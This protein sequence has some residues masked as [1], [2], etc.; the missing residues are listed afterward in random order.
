[1]KRI[2]RFL[3]LGLAALP[4]VF[5]IPADEESSEAPAPAT[6]S[7]NHLAKFREWQKSPGSTENG[8]ALAKQRKQKML[9]LMADDP[10]A[11]IEEA[12]GWDEY[13]ALPAAVRQHVEQPF[14]GGQDSYQVEIE[15]GPVPRIRAEFDG[16]MA[17][18][19]GRRMQNP[20]SRREH[21]AQGIRLD[22]RVVLRENHVQRLTVSEARALHRHFP[23]ANPNPQFDIM[24]GERID[25]ATEVVALYGA[26]L[27]HF[28]DQETLTNF[29]EKITSL[30]SKPGPQNGS[31]VFFEGLELWAAAYEDANTFNWSSVEGIA[32]SMARTWTGTERRAYVFAVSFPDLAANTVTGND[33]VE[34]INGP[35]SAAL[36][37]MSY[38]K[39]HARGFANNASWVTDHPSTYY[40]G[41]TDEDGNAP[42]DGE[43]KIGSIGGEVIAKLEAANPGLDL[44]AEYDVIIT[45]FPHLPGIKSAAAIGGSRMRLN[46]TTATNV[47][48]H[49]MLHHLGMSHSSAW[50]SFTSNPAD[51]VGTSIEY[52][53]PFDV[54]ANANAPYS[55]LRAQGKV[56]LNWL[57]TQQWTEVTSSG[58]Y[59]IYP[60]DLPATDSA[61]ATRALKI[62]TSEPDQSL[63]VSFRQGHPGPESLRRGASITWQKEETTAARAWLL[64]MKPGG[65]DFQDPGLVVGQTFSNDGVHI[66]TSGS[67]GVAPNQWLEVRVKL[68]DSPG[69]ASPTG[70]LV[71]PTTGNARNSVRFTMDVTDA[72]NSNLV[73]H[74]D[75]GNGLVLQSTQTIDH[76]FA[77]GGTYTVKCVASDM[78]GGT[79]EDSL[80]ITVDDPLTEWTLRGSQTSE[81]LLD[82]AVNDAGTLA[83]A[84]GENGAL[85]TSANGTNW[86]DRSLT[87][88]ADLRG[89]C[90][91]EFHG[92]W[93][94]SGIESGLGVIYSSPDGVSWTQVFHSG[95]A[96]WRIACNPEGRIVATGFVGVVRVSSNGTI[97]ALSRIDDDRTFKNISYGEGRFI[98]V[99][100][101]GPEDY[102]DLYYS[103]LGYTWTNISQNIHGLQPGDDVT[104]LRFV[105]DRFLLTGTE[106]TQIRFS[107]D[108]G[109]NFSGRVTEDRR[110]NAL[111]PDAPRW[112][113]PAMAYGS[114][115]YFAAG[116]NTRGAE[117]DINLISL[118][119]AH[120]QAV[121]AQNQKN[122]NAAAFI[123]ATFITV[124][125]DGK[126]WQSDPILPVNPSYSFW[127]QRYRIDLAE[128]LGPFADPDGD[129]QNNLVEYAAWTDP[130]DPKSIADLEVT[131]VATATGIY[132]QFSILRTAERPDID[133]Q[134]LGSEDLTKWIVL[135]ATNSDRVDNAGAVR[136]R[137]LTTIEDTSSYF[138]R[139]EPILTE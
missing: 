101:N 39:V 133:Y 80:T 41:T 139:F 100:D 30:E 58:V 18:V 75:L 118:D 112:N 26:R 27:F 7:E 119:G 104:A 110:S 105:E 5:L 73:Y 98:A 74:W 20:L 116:V 126:I 45:H 86:T 113:C 94:V 93:F 60:F 134:V 84:C 12:L 65:S 47:F 48:V 53:H 40:L 24:S 83:V 77:V 108:G 32:E 85:V 120:F 44:E 87:S 137:S 31:G 13:L 115:V 2:A 8:I 72:D 64:D 55:H 123:N 114:L 97:W 99:A 106:G 22:G 136:V 67:G 34:Q 4:V 61:N 28:A 69:N 82:V 54:M 43:T 124:G 129:G 21:A 92:K 42:G 79:F 52:G 3:P 91:S 90:W 36:Q 81:T 102:P 56:L 25:P 127:Q 131:S 138:F 1:M 88:P 6:V 46:G 57:G 71:G 89:V 107:L 17:S 117:E 132:P 14:S 125:V 11:A 63:W 78:R 95:A 70:S 76:A 68:G 130:S 50:A 15:C 9:Q 103:E 19:F 122:R 10:R 96:L 135:D 49:E 109:E 37:D 128:Q 29:E 23:A 59:R 38:G 62:P 35:V 33:L 51:I 111:A 121:P 16:K 66:T